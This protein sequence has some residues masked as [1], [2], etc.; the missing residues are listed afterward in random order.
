MTLEQTTE[1]RA[2]RPAS[3]KIIKKKQHWLL[4]V[5]QSGFD[6]ISMNIEMSMLLWGHSSGAW[7]TTVWRVVSAMQ[8]ITE[9]T[10]IFGMKNL[11]A[12]IFKWQILP[13]WA[14]LNMIIFRR[15]IIELGASKWKRA[16]TTKHPVHAFLNSTFPPCLNSSGCLS[17]ALQI[18]TKLSTFSW[19]DTLQV[20]ASC[21]TE[22]FSKHWTVK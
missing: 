15:S 16:V 18:C 4:C 9:I 22:N 3:A 11:Q 20:I 6:N 14:C 17:S 8:L 2:V 10:F 13:K 21:W 7:L 1:A 12:R 5:P 19:L